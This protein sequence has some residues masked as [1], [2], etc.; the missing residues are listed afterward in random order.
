MPKYFDFSGN[1]RTYFPDFII[2]GKYI[3]ESKPK[4]LW[5]SDN[6]LRKKE[7]AIKFANE[8]NFKYKLVDVGKLTD[9]EIKKLYDNG[10]IKFIDRYEKLYQEKFNGK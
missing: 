8:F 1:E 9:L 5:S 2:N 10:L 6:V 7:A 4:R 3:I